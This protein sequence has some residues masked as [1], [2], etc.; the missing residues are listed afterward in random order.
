SSDHAKVDTTDEIGARNHPRTFLDPAGMEDPF[1]F[2]R[3][4][5]VDTTDQIIAR[6]NFTSFVD[7]LRMIDLSGDPPQQS[8]GLGDFNEDGRINRW[9]VNALSEVLANEGNDLRYDV[10]E[11][12]FVDY[13]D[14]STLLV[15]VL[16]TTIADANLDGRT[17][18]GDY[19]IWQANR[20]QQTTE[21]TRG[22]LNADGYVDVSDFNIWFT[23]RFIPLDV[24]RVADTAL[25]IPRAALSGVVVVN[26]RLSLEMPTGRPSR[27]R[28]F[29]DLFSTAE[30]TQQSAAEIMRIDVPRDRSAPAR[31]VR[32]WARRQRADRN[33]GDTGAGVIDK[34]FAE[35][36]SE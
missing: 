26:P 30:L 34:F 19:S 35:E 28:A 25:R 2:D 31:I 10:D 12:G 20:F 36:S 17:D 7:E 33:D 16:G 15:D 32:D 24:A 18:A 8:A 6:N 13:A 14:L 21:F 4:G 29:E 9:D 23:H 3:D 22:D 11:D 27:D 5:R 1:D